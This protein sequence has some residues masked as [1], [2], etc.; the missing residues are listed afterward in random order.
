MNHSSDMNLYNSCGNCV[1]KT[2]AQS[3]ET[4]RNESAN[5]VVRA[6]DCYAIL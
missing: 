3:S 1:I 4:F 6:G 2:N 5:C